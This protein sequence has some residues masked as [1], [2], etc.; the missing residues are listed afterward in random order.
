M[1]P[2]QNTIEP[3]WLECQRG[4]WES[5]VHIYSLSWNLLSQLKICDSEDSLE[6]E[7]LAAAGL[8]A[9]EWDTWWW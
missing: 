7:E 8:E 5:Q 6:E 4:I 9:V 3:V 2:F 1:L